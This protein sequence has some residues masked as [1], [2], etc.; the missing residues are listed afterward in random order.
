MPLEKWK[1][2]R[3]ALAG[4]IAEGEL[5][6]G[7]RLPTEAE[8]AARF[9]VGRHSIRRAVAELAQAGRLS[10]EQGRGTF[11]SEAPRITYLIGRR[12]RA[13]QN[14]RAQGL[15]VRRLILGHERR[16]APGWVARALD[17]APGSEVIS[18]HHMILAD[19]VPISVGWGNAP[20]ARFPDFIERRSA[21]GSM[22][23]TWAAYG[24][25]DYLRADTSVH[26]RPATPAEARALRQHPQM[27]VMVVHAVDAEPDGTPIFA[28]EVIWSA[29]RVKFTIMEDGAHDT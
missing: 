7:A 9:E 2:V 10:V 26:A 29:A 21:S 1:L 4:M 15:K 11:V 22:T 28:S 3:D 19:E 5:G 24:I 13:G 16:V 25:N 23:A 20:A 12:T 14:L 17:L 8:L 6:P 27:P 18:S